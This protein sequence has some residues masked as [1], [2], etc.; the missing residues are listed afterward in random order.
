MDLPKLNL[1]SFPFQLKKRGDKLYISCIV[2]KKD[3]LLTPEEW[4]RQNILYYLIQNQ[5]YPLSLLAVEKQLLVN[6][7]K[8]R[9]DLLVYNKKLEPILLG[10][11]KSSDTQLD[12]NT[13][14]QIVNY[15]KAIRVKNL[16]ISNGIQHYHI[17]ID[18]E[19]GIMENYFEIPDFQFII[20][21]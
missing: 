14:K 12:E 18:F 6:G 3:I 11:F 5:G 17:R 21:F 4:V 1:P 10:E 16:L 7:L 13:L 9:F 19:N 2:R 20:Q 15:N 8:K